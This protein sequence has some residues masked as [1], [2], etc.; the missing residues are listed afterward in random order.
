MK[1]KT[2]WRPTTHQHYALAEYAAWA[3]ATWKEQ[4]RADWLRSGSAWRSE[5]SDWCYLQQLRNAIHFDLA[6]Y[7]PGQ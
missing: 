4:L 7:H 2:S 1:D 6:A 5:T 3:G